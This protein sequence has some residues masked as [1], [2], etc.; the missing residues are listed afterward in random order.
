MKYLQVSK[1]AMTSKS[2]SAEEEAASDEDDADQEHRL[3]E[4]IVDRREAHARV[5]YRPVHS[6]KFN[7]VVRG[8][9]AG[10][11][12]NPDGAERRR[13]GNDAHAKFSDG[14]RRLTEVEGS[15]APFESKLD[16]EIAR[17]A[18]TRGPGSTALDE[19][20]KIDGVSHRQ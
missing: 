13:D 14:L 6:A 3:R 20:L 5:S 15:Y 2:G 18:K 17:W 1:G 12:Y 9:E 11:V 7:D 10:K 8:A 19:L 4:I 16:W